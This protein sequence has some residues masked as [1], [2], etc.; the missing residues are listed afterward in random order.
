MAAFCL[1]LIIS[2]LFLRCTIFLCCTIQNSNILYTSIS[3]QLDLSYLTGTLAN[4]IVPVLCGSAFKNR[5][6]QTLLDAVVDYLPSPL[7][8]P[9]IIGRHPLD[10]NIIEKFADDDAPLAALAFKVSF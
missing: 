3:T 9:P 4:A 1:A 5:G 2:N 8:V 6:V 7:D 10:D